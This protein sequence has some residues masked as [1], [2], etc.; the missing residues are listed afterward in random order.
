MQNSSEISKL[1]VLPIQVIIDQWVDCSI[2]P[3]PNRYPILSACYEPKTCWNALRWQLQSFTT[4]EKL[5]ELCVPH[6]AGLPRNGKSL[7]N[8]DLFRDEQQPNC[9]LS[10]EVRCPLCGQELSWRIQSQNANRAA[11]V[12]H[13]QYQHACNQLSLKRSSS[14]CCRHFQLNMES[15]QKNPSLDCY[16]SWLCC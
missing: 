8:S 10:P 14:S 1:V 16:A 12:K 9:S 3:T 15:L 6:D 4:A 5:N 7:A 11:H 13:G 2:I